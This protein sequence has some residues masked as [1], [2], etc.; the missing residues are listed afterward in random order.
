MAASDTYILHGDDGRVYRI[1][2]ADLEAFRVS[3]EEP[4]VRKA[5]ADAEAAKATARA[6]GA[7]FACLIATRV[8][9]PDDRSVSGGAGD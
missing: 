6:A 8:Q 7:L 1:S 4:E 5:V 3:D 2:A 9:A